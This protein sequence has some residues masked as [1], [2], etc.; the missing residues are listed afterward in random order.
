MK[1]IREDLEN[2]FETK[3][4]FQD[5]NESNEILVYTWEADGIEEAISSMSWEQIKAYK[6]VKGIKTIKEE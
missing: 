6:K 3:L 4:I 5:G 2:S 1:I